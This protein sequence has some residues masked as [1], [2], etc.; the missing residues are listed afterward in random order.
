MNKESMKYLIKQRGYTNQKVASMLGYSV[1]TF[2]KLMKR[3]PCAI[4]YAI[5]GLPEISHIKT[6]RLS[7]IR[8]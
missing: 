6:E 1:P 4:Y 7:T 3:Y 5:K 2:E 8:P